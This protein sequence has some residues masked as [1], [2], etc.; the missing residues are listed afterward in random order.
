MSTEIMELK[1]TFKALLQNL[2][3]RID[4]VCVDLEAGQ[5]TERL[6][7]W[8]E[9]LS[10]FTETLLVL[11]ESHVL[12]LDID[13]FNEKAEILLNKIEQKDDLFISDLLKYEIKPLL[14]YWDGCI[15][16]D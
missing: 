12:D 15:T 10:V 7:Y 4:P 6:S 3:T 16:N 9:D 14:T 5:A 11:S 1:V 2:V 13:I 8:L